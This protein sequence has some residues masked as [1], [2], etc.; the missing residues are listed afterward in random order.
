MSL[1]YK[2]RRETPSRC[3]RECVSLPDREDDIVLTSASES[4]FFFSTERMTYSEER[5]SSLHRGKSAPLLDVEEADSFS[6]QKRESVFS[7]QRRQCP[8]V[9]HRGESVYLL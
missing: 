6:V 1:F 3:K 9:I 7:T 8:S 2:G 4:V 5:V